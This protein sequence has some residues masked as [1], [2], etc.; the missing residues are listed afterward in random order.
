[1]SKCFRSPHDVSLLLSRLLDSSQQILRRG[2]FI[3]TERFVGVQVC[4]LVSVCESFDGDVVSRLVSNTKIGGISRIQHLG[5]V[6]A[7]LEVVI[8]LTEIGHVGF[9]L[10]EKSSIFVRL[11][12]R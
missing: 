10:L 9:S 7:A 4:L 2:V 12:S 11:V 6:L 5:L 8:S 3:L 1:M